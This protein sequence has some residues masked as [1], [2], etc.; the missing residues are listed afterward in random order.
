[1]V[2]LLRLFL[3]TFNISSNEGLSAGSGDKH[4][5]INSRQNFETDED[6]DGREILILDVH[7][8]RIQDVP[9]KWKLLTFIWF[10]LCL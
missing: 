8:N 4:L 1:M 10:F 6:G 9:N 3:I 5:E 7:P 2:H